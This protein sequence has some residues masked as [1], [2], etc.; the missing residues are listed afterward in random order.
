MTDALATLAEVACTHYLGT[1]PLATTLAAWWPLVSAAVIAQAHRQVVLAWEFQR[2]RDL[3]RVLQPAVDADAAPSRHRDKIWGGLQR[4]VNLLLWHLE[5]AGSDVVADADACVR[6]LQLIIAVPG[7]I[8]AQDETAIR[9]ATPPLL[10][11]TSMLEEAVT[12]IGGGAARGGGLGLW[13]G[14]A[15]L[16]GSSYHWMLA[17]HK[18]TTGETEAAAAEYA[19]CR[20]LVG[21]R[22]V[23]LAHRYVVVCACCY[24][25]ARYA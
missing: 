1:G 5:T 12:M 22:T 3:E 18:D 6:A 16:L 14:M 4:L 15:T 17:L 9:Y 8:T 21:E 10:S 25:L 13:D 19:I 23:V 24:V 7:V 11:G 20:E 2:A